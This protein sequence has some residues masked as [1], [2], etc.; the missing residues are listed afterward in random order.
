MAAHYN[1]GWSH[2]KESLKSGQYDTLKGSFYVNQTSSF[3]QEQSSSTAVAISEAQA[4]PAY[5]S[6]PDF[7]APNLWPPEN[8][9]PGFRAT[10]EELCTLI[11]DIAALVGRA[12]D[13]YGTKRIEDYPPGHVERVVKTSTTN[14]ARLLHYFPAELSNA[15]TQTSSFPT[16]PTSNP[17]TSDED[18]EDD[19]WCATHIDDSCLTGLTSAVYI[20]E[21]NLP[22][23]PDPSTFQLPLPILDSSPDPLA[24]LYIRSRSSRIVK[25]NIPPSCLAFQ[26]G[27]ALQ[28]ITEGKFRAVPHFVR[29]PRPGFGAEGMKVARNTL[30]VF[31]QPNLHEIVDRKSGTTFADQQILSTAKYYPGVS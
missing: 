17:N 5:G 18:S 25:V 29:A 24:G 30:A 19:S 7:L 16:P 26:T 27:E 4:N 23:S 20:D 15:G 31:T 9:L 13:L 11:I 21:S 28:T 3:L 14:K 1:I 22:S 8:L 12:I 2:G 10:F 6:L